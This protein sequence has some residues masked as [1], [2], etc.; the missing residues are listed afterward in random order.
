MG[1][2]GKM[3]GEEV[4]GDKLDGIFGRLGVVAVV[5]SK[6]GV[7]AGDRGGRKMKKGG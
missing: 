2:L 5:A 1:T 3:R 7:V 4:V 6:K